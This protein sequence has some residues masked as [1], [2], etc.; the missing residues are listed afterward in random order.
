MATVSLPAT[1]AMSQDST[2]F[3]IDSSI[4]LD[5]SKS[6]AQQT[7]EKVKAPTTSRDVFIFLVAFRIVNAL[8]VKTL[9]QPDEYFQSLEPAWE[10]AFGANSGAWIT[11][12][13]WFK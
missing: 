9:F 1:P 2:V 12:V 10:I 11:W 6:L 5:H 7:V 3:G 4:T 8:S 13:R